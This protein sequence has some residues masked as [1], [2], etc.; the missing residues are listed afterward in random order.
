MNFKE[1]NNFESAGFRN[2]EIEKRDSIKKSLE[3]KVKDFG[4]LFSKSYDFAIKECPDII[5]SNIEIDTEEK[6][7]VLKNT[8]GF[9]KHQGETK[10]G[11]NPLV[12]MSA[13]GRD[14]YEYLMNSRKAT[15]D[16]C[17]KLLGVSFDELTPEILSC[18]IFL[19]EVG[20]TY[21]YLIN[22]PV[23]KE[24][25]E[26]RKKE[27]N[28]LPIPGYNPV[29]LIKEFGDE[30]T[31]LGKW[32]ADNAVNIEKNGYNGLHSKQEIINAQEI[33]YHSLETEMIPDRFATSILLKY[34][35]EIFG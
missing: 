30:S 7:S 6:Y 26:K 20:H 32:Y 33:A 9:A 15:V 25:M 28:T 3:G 21:D 2:D 18:F 29:N 23:Y 19:H 12:V 35:K 27:M 4:L 1:K 11:I 24:F 8:G 34:K 5:H 22:N 31:P 14:H 17:A 13:G 10:L 16:I